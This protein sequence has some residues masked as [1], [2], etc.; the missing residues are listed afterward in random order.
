MALAFAVVYHRA[1]VAEDIPK[2]SAADKKRVRLAIEEKLT[3]SP[4]IFGK[5]LRHSL[6]GYRSLRVGDHRV[7]FRIDGARVRV[8]LIE[9]RSVVYKL[10]AAR[11]GS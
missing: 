4:A 1:V 10:A 2:L 5:P 3:T 9:H 6:R 7:V 11:I 8:L